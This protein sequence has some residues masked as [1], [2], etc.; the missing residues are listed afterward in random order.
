MTN[1][2]NGLRVVPAAAAAAGLAESAGTPF[3]V[4]AAGLA[5]SAGTPVAVAAAGL[6]GS[7]G[8]SAAVTVK[9]VVAAAADIR[10]VVWVA[11]AAEKPAE[12]ANHRKDRNL[13]CL[14]APNRNSYRILP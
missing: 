4:A 11:L 8:I 2:T 3:A 14:S 13:S 10:A 5:G 12:R 1:R 7:A 6:A 9:L